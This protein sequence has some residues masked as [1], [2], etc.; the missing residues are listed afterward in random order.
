[1]TGGPMEPSAQKML[2]LMRDY[3]KTIEANAEYVGG[4]FAE[5]ARKMHYEE[6]GKRGIYGE[7]RR[8]D[9]EALLEE[10]IEI[11]PLPRLP[12]DAN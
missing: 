5:E 2:A 12:E 3:R 10:G 1:V 9:A 6:T 8:E 7:A 11:H 4:R